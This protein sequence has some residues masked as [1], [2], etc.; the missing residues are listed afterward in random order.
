MVIYI[1]TL[2][3]MVSFFTRTGSSLKMILFSLNPQMAAYASLMILD[4]VSVFFV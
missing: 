3:I 4:N 1:I 2:V